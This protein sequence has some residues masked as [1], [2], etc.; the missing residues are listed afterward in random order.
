MGMGCDFIDELIGANQ[1]TQFYK[2][3]VP[4]D[5]LDVYCFL[6]FD[7]IFFQSNEFVCPLCNNKLPENEVKKI[8]SLKR[9]DINSFRFVCQYGETIS[10]YKDKLKNYDNMIKEEEN[11]LKTLYYKHK[12]IKINQEIYLCL[13]TGNG[14]TFENYIFSDPNISLNIHDMIYKINI[15]E[16]STSNNN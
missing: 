2:Y 16:K 9:K 12:C 10:D 3:C 13:Y 5:G 8:K 4:K 14:Y 1:K 15:E 6:S 11:F 7:K